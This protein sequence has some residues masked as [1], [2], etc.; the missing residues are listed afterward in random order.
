METVHLLLVEDDRAY[1]RLLQIQL[2]DLV[3][4]HFDV[5]HVSSL[6][7]TLQQLKRT[8]FDIALVDLIMPGIDGIEFHCGFS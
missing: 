2:Q 5:I 7:K 6:E 1:A 3:E 8:T 4:N